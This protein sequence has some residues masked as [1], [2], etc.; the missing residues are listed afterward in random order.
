MIRPREPRVSDGEERVEKIQSLGRA[1][2][3][4]AVP[5]EI[6][7]REVPCVELGQLAHVERD[8]LFGLR[9]TH[10]L[11]D[12]EG[13]L[14]LVLLYDVVLNVEDQGRLGRAFEV[15]QCRL[16]VYQTK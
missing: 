7:R 9:P 13:V 4:K 5:G 11:A 15:A 12:S 1:R 3:D 6:A 16:D 2:P 14:A 10:D 8:A